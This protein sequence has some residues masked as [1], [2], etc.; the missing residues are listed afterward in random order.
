MRYAGYW[1]TLYTLLILS[2]AMALVVFLPELEP[3]VAP[4]VTIETRDVQIAEDRVTFSIVGNKHRDCQLSLMTFAWRFDSTVQVAEVY[5]VVSDSIF[6]AAPVVRAGEEFTFGRLYT[7]F[8]AAVYSLPRVEF[9]ATLYYNCHGLYLTPHT[10][11][12]PVNVP[13]PP[14]QLSGAQRLVQ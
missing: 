12:I 9:R 11:N 1:A 3:R 2:C 6:R 4:V 13:H 14:E 8:P 7:P 5:D 10:F